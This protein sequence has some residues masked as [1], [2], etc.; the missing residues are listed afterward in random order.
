[1]AAVFRQNLGTQIK[2]GP[3]GRA[4]RVSITRGIAMLTA[5]ASYA[6]TLTTLA[7]SN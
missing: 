6:A 7:S 3:I 2:T 5:S 1:M 4:A